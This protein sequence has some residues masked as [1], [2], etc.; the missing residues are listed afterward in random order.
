MKVNTDQKRIDEILDRGVTEVVTKESVRAKLSSG[1]KLRVKHGVDPTTQDLHLGHGVPYLRLR[2]LQDLGHTVIFLIGDFTGRFGDPESKQET[3][4]MRAKQEVR[5]MAEQ[6]LDQACMILDRSHLEIRYNSEWYDKMSAEDLLRLISTFTVDQM[7]ERDMFVER[8]AHKRPI[9]MHEPVYPI[10]QGYDSVMLK[11]DLTV[12]GQDQLFNEARGRDLQKAHGQEPQDIIA[13]ALLVGTD[14][15]RKMSQSLNNAIL[16]KDPASEK[17]GKIMSVPDSR[18]VQYF[19]LA[20]NVPTA[21]IREIQKGL[22]QKTLHPRDAKLKLARRI[23]ELYHS[24]EEAEKAEQGFIETFSEGKLPHDIP[25]IVLPGTSFSL[26][27]TVVA[28]GLATSKSE[29][30][31]LIRAGAVEVNEMVRKNPDERV[32]QGEI[33]LRVG[34]HRFI[35]IKREQR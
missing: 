34:K 5:E 16:F 31:R 10:L 19:T 2:A 3:R 15:E 20:T 25:E 12:I 29:A 9:G 26:L 23:V 17:F 27:E 14:G 4:S 21:E 32:E 7:L 11:S 1:K 28:S 8:R 22:E 18:I 30:R 6:Y 13:T 35:K 24:P 33:L